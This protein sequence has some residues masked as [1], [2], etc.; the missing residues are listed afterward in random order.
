M[1]TVD[2]HAIGVAYTAHD[3]THCGSTA[4]LIEK[5]AAARPPTKAPA[6]PSDDATIGEGGRN[7]YLTREAG[8]LR[9][10]GVDEDVLAA[11]LANLNEKNCN[12]PLD[13]AEVLKI[14]KSV[15]RY[16]A[17]PPEPARGF[18]IELKAG[19]STRAL[20]QLTAA[21]PAIADQDSLMVYA[22]QLVHPYTGSQPGF[23]GEPVEVLELNT[24]TPLAL[25]SYINAR[26]AFVGWRAVKGGKL[27]QVAEECP[28]SLVR[29]FME[30]ADLIA[31]LPTTGH[32]ACHNADL[33]RQAA[34][35]D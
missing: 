3:S 23:G 7:A 33:A 26:V 29:T 24:L 13:D 8:K 2:T 21:I 25:A 15:G 6:P 11:A 12:P 19:E 16:E 14:A 34:C 32:R 9:R 30:R 31:G 27:R 28:L 17:P 35:G 22:Q 5:L 18:T 10:L 20:T 4:A 1:A